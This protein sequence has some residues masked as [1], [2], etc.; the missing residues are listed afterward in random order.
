MEDVLPQEEDFLPDDTSLVNQIN[1]VEEDSIVSEPVVSEQ[2]N[3]VVVGS[4]PVDIN[5]STQGAGN[6]GGVNVGSGNTNISAEVS[7]DNVF[8]N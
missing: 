6:L 2:G 3:T 7:G 5:A 4:A 1:Q 8:V